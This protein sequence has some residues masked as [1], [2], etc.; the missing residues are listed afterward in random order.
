LSL[1]YIRLRDEV[2][3]RRKEARQCM[4]AVK[5]FLI[6]RGFG[7]VTEPHGWLGIFS[8]KVAAHS[9]APENV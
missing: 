9:R 5:D 8:F 6:Q 2:K 1:I 7:V 3:Q 4:V